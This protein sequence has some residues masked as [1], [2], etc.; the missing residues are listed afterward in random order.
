M[1]LLNRIESPREEVIR[2]V[3]ELGISPW[4][5][6]TSPNGNGLQRPLSSSLTHPQ[7]EPLTHLWTRRT[8]LSPARL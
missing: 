1:N 3:H 8:G 6:E 7:Q 4:P 2:G 5:P